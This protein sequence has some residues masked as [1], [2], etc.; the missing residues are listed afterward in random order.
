MRESRFIEVWL[1]VFLK[2]ERGRKVAERLKF[3]V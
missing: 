2:W 1:L 3:N